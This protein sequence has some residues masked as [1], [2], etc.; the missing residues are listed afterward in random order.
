LSTFIESLEEP[1][2]IRT[3]QEV[4]G[5]AQNDNIHDALQRHRRFTRSFPSYM[6]EKV[7]SKRSV[8]AVFIV[9]FAFN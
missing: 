6:Q 1:M 8:N 2:G 4:D 9:N 7:L 5:V 3:L